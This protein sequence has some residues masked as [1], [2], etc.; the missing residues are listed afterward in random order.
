MLFSLDRGILAAKAG[1]RVPLII[2]SEKSRIPCEKGLRA[3]GPLLLAAL[4][5][6]E[7]KQMHVRTL[8]TE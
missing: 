8:Q 7:V 6:L 1:S 4:F 2:T 5:V 3:G